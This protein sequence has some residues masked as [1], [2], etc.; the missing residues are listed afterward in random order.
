MEDDADWDVRL[1]PSLNGFARGARYIQSA[2]PT[3]SLLSPYG[4][5]WDVLWVGHCGRTLPE[6]DDRVFVI[7]DDPSIPPP[8]HQLPS[9]R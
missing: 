4:D 3:A 7:P 2:P 6:N 5:D 9:P 8:P 1:K